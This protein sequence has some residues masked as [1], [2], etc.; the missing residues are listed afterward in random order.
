MFA[1]PSGIERLF[2][3][4]PTRGILWVCLR[5]QRFNFTTRRV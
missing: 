2:L 5:E 1:R 3:K 4:V